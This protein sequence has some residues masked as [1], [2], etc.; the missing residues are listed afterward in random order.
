VVGVAGDGPADVAVHHLGA[1][2]RAEELAARLRE[3]LPRAARLRERLPRAARLLVS[4]M[5][6]Y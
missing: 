2:D 6:A 4:E 1:A 5:G 3:R